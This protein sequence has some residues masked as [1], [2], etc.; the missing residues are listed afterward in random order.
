MIGK[1][2]D[3]RYEILSQIGGGG[4]ALVFKAQDLLLNRHV[5]IKI[6]RKQYIHDQEFVRRFQRE[7]QSAA[8]I[9]HPNIVSIYDVGFQ[10][11]IHY[12]V[13]EYV[14]GQ[15]LNEWISE[16]APLQVDEAVRIAEQIGEALE[17]AHQ[18]QIVHRDIKPHN[19]L[20]GKNGRIKVT[21]FGIARAAT[22]STIT[23]TG[24]VVGSV[25]YF[26]PEHAK[27]IH[28]SE[29]SDLYSLG[30]VIYQMVTGKLPFTGESP[31]SVALMHLQQPFV[32]PRVLNPL[33]PQSLENI[34]L[35][36]L[37][38]NPAERHDRASDLIADLSSCLS[39]ERIH[40]SKLLFVDN[41]H[42][43]DETRVI[44]AIKDD[45]RFGPGGEI[46][47]T[48]P[49]RPY[50]KKPRDESDAPL[51]PVGEFSSDLQEEE[52]KWVRPAIWGGVLAA[53]FLLM[54]LGFELVR[55]LFIV[56]EVRVP[57]VEKLFVEDAETKL[58]DVGLVPKR[59]TIFDPDVDKDV[60]V[61]QEPRDMNVKVKSQ[62]TLYVSRGAE[63][64]SMA[65]YIGKSLDETK[66][67]LKVLGFTDEQIVIENEE[68]EAPAGTVINQNP[69]ANE[70][71]KVEK[72]VVKLT[73]SSGKKTFQMP[74]LLG[75]SQAEAV[76]I[77]TKNKLKL[78]ENGVVLQPSFKYE[79]GVVFEQ[80]PF[81]P[82]E[83]VAEGNELTIYV[84][85][86]YPA[87]ARVE[88]IDLTV[89]PSGENVAT[90]IKIIYSDARGDN[91]EWGTRSITQTTTYPVKVVLSPDK[92]G[93]IEI[94]RD[95]QL[96]DYRN[97]NY[98][99]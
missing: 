39:A 16:H 4:M 50:I 78:A 9:S 48:P 20:L 67:N 82:D 46:I 28:V 90:E 17:H 76:S 57:I 12:I 43:F 6:L 25:H 10:N 29:Q 5:A 58:R 74:N 27:G 96:V 45:I 68:N 98:A 49:K 24:S 83:I 34:I 61:R 62:I 88:V 40:E 91:I 21:D 84:S 23:Q 31:I 69:I 75:I 8:S 32:E 41:D 71:F 59:V 77:I 1:Q 13:M 30:I 2:L 70:E 52:K 26:S 63:M 7:A 11:D 65:S 73:V 89:E 44:P 54:W 86:G 97:V 37:R 36:L 64:L 80:K 18:N 33:I 79:K 35:R 47:H 60:V 42:D 55:G 22:S 3:G 92:N 85:S 53:C 38:K 99:N 15:N 95:G 56:D 51:E 93:L 19:I 72:S 87:D 81:Q 14:D 66:A 94:Y